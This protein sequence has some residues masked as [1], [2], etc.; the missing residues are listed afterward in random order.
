[1]IFSV[2]KR[3]SAGCRLRSAFSDAPRFLRPHLN[4]RVAANCCSGA[5][6]LKL[7]STVVYRTAEGRKV[8]LTVVQIAHLRILERL[9]L[10]LWRPSAPLRCR[11]ILAIRPPRRLAP[12][13]AAI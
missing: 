10:F 7:F 3:F 11:A 4:Y 2:A 1:M 13:V 5:P 12:R 6:W 9:H 8:L